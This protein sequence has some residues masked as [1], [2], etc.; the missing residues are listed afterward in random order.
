VRAAAVRR[1]LQPWLI[2]VGIDAAATTVAWSAVLAASPKSIPFATTG[3]LAAVAV[4]VTLGSLA[5]RQLYREHVRRVLSVELSGLARAAFVA[6]VAV[7]VGDDVLGRDSGLRTAA[8]GFALELALLAAAR[9]LARAVLCAARRSGR[10]CR[11]V[12]LVGES[13][14]TAHLAEELRDRPSEGYLVVG[15]VG[16]ERAHRL[17]GVSCPY[18]G[19]VDDMEQVL[20]TT[21]A[22]AAIVA[23]DGLGR[24]DATDVVRRLVETGVSVQ[25][26]GTLGL[27]H[28]RLRATAI[29]QETAFFVERVALTGPQRIVKRAIDFAG[30]AAGLV[31][32]SPLLVAAAVAVKLH[33]GGPV[34]FRQRR[35]GLHGDLFPMVK[36]R[37]MVVDAEAQ[38]PTIEHEN[39]RSGPM[40]KHEAD[41][42][43]TRPGRLLRAA[44]IDELPQLWNVLKGQMSLVGPR[45]ALPG[46]AALFGENLN[47]RHTVR[48]GI[49]GLWQVEARDSERFEDLERHDLF[50]VENWSVLLDLALLVRTVGGVVRRT[51]RFSRHE[52]GTLL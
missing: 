38:R 43:V 13:S 49:T 4:A 28:R 35:V 46:E 33:D 17:R 10:F 47:R 18:L 15:A 48:P 29:G 24:R 11:R 21:G 31:L 14:A 34:L 40:F 16:D 1:R 42:R 20:A 25:L 37:T 52:S 19:Q 12:L 3:L 9:G 22:T 41:P 2:L 51:W 45:P 30:A 27:H 44:S 39:R 8:A 23:T 50:Y 6:A 7:G 5:A 36:L 32:A 26:A